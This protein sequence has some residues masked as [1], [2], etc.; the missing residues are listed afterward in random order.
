MPNVTIEDKGCR[1]CTLC[2]DVCPVD[3]FDYDTGANLAKVAR[4]ED[5]I[6]CLSCFYVCPSQCVALTDVDH[7]RPFHRI[8][9]NVALLE[10]FLQAKTATQTLTAE[11]YDEALKDVA[12]R[13]HALADATTETMGRGQKAVGRKAGGLA[14][15]HLPEMYEEIGMSQV[16]TRMQEHFRHSFDFDFTEK[17]GEYDLTFHPCGLVQVVEG[18][19]QKVGDAVLCDLFHEYWSGLVSAFAGQTYR[20][21]VPQA[22]ATCLMKLKRAERH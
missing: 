6:G 1:G 4:T 9:K 5:C 19:G 13:L 12:A 22:G 18:A 14:A 10:H 15:D 17:D 20:C 2:V 8:E 3:V 16:M 21:Q 11:D 7:L